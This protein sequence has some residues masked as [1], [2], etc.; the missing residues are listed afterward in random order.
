MEGYIYM[1]T[2]NITNKSY[3]G[4]TINL[5]KRKQSHENSKRNDEFH[6]ALREY[7]A[8]NF[9]FIILEK[10]LGIDKKEVKTKLNELEINLISKYNTRHPN[11][12]NLSKGGEG[13][14]DRILTKEHKRKISESNKGRILTEE[15]KRKLHQKRSKETCKRIGESKKGQIPWNKGLKTDK[16]VIEKQVKAR[17]WFYNSGG[18]NKGKKMS[19]EQ[20]KKLSIAHTGKHLSEEAKNKLREYNRT[21]PEKY[22]SIRGIKLSE[23]HKRRISEANKGIARTK[24]KIWITNEIDN[25]LINPEQI[26]EYIEFGYKRG[27]TIKNKNNEI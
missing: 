20:K 9:S 25:K 26:F 16:K 12:Y 23:K 4:Q 24:G 18:P 7:G 21:H 1:Y 6:K 8:D 2:N 14:K 15:H 17:Q 3:I 10:I 13:C 5:K 22:N 11:G 27:R 19:E